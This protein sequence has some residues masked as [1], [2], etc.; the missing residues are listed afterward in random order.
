MSLIYKHTHAHSAASPYP[1]VG[2][3]E[4]R[5]AGDAIAALK[6]QLAPKCHVC[7]DGE[8]KN[9][10]A[11]FLV[12]GDVIELKI[13]DV[14]PADGVILEGIPIQVDQAALTG[15]SLP[16]TVQPW[17][18]VL[19][20]SAIKRGEIKAV[21]GATGKDTFFGKAAGMI[22]GVQSTGHLAKV[23]WS[24]TIVL[25]ILSLVLCAII[26]AVIYTTPDPVGYNRT[27]SKGIAT[28]SV[29]IVILVASIPIAIEVVCTSTLAVGSHLMAH[30]KV[31][32]ARLSAIE[33]LAG[34]T[35]L[36]SDK[37]GTLTL[38]KLSLRDP[39]ILSPGTTAAVSRWRRR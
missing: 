20:G 12:P 39:I 24:I 11:K 21:V 14:V 18:P 7:R 35:I 13:G 29:V 8:W 10:N 33:E 9:M 38:N 5:N 30:H 19:M 34:M 6:S 28:L 23:L 16:V 31:I 4:E 27:G 36:C 32:V 22:A 26:F 3:I 37:T 2:F 17:G 1:P 15:E 25:L